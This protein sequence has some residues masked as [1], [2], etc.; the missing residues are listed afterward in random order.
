MK[1]LKKKI[2]IAFALIFMFAIAT[3]LTTIPVADAAVTEF[4]NGVTLAISTDLVGNGQ[5]VYILFGLFEAHPQSVGQEGPRWDGITLEITT[6]DQKT[7]TL[8]PYSAEATGKIVLEYTVDQLG[9]YNFE[10]I[11]PGQWVNISDTNQRW[12]LPDRSGKV[13]LTVQENPI[14]T[15]DKS[16]PLPT[17]YWT[18]PINAENKAWWQVA[19]DWLMLNYNTPQRAFAASTVWAPYTS[20]PNSAHVLWK[21][22]IRFG[23]VSGG[24]SQDS[25][26]HVGIASNQPFRPMI[27]QGRVFYQDQLPSGRALGTRFLDLYTGEEIMYLNDTQI[28]FAQ[29]Y[30][31][32][33]SETEGIYPFIWETSGSTWKMR[34]SMSARLILTFTDM[35][36][37]NIFPGPNGEI[38]KYQFTGSRATRRLTL[39]NSTKAVVTTVNLASG[40]NPF[41]LPLDRVINGTTG[42]EW[43]VSI[44]EFPERPTGTPSVRNMFS[45]ESNVIIGVLRD[46]SSYPPLFY[47]V[48]FPALIEKLSNGSYPDTLNYLWYEKRTNYEGAYERMRGTIQDGKFTQFDEPSTRTFV[49]DVKTGKQLFET[50]RLPIGWTWAGSGRQL[51]YGKLYT[52]SYD[53]NVRAYD[54]E[55]G[56]LL[57]TS[58]L[59]NSGYLENAYGTYPVQEG[60]VIADGKIFVTSGERAVP[61][62]PWRGSKLWVIDAETGQHLWNITGRFRYNSISDGILVSLNIMDGQAYAI[63]KGP[64]STSVTAPDIGIPWGQSIVI[65]GTVTDQSPAQKGTA[66]ISDASMTAWM[67][68]LHMQKPFPTDATG[69]PIKIDVI[70]ANGNYRT[71]GT[72][73]SDTSGNFGFAWTPDIQGSY[74]VKTTFEG[75]NSYGS[76]YSMTYF[77]VQDAPAAT[78][79]PTAPSTPMTDTYLLGATI[80]I[81]LAIAVAVLLI[82]K[83]R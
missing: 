64:T 9:V 25:T 32:S 58:Y 14:A 46:T 48:A 16:P 37:G 44:P 65:K 62:P 50:E 52:A 3:P 28:S 76:S 26:F 47:H 43:S 66:A 29:N 35:T 74:M 51:A 33:E 2:T 17:D 5:S 12:Y 40:T 11:F 68:Y 83:K 10:T 69:V 27:Q 1:L 20:A 60:F 81:I 78:P 71:I 13:S 77:N 23:G 15:Y 34:D 4:F 19:D 72:T 75:S 22:L 80:S 38:L 24:P 73:T 41:N 21:E 53:G 63:G 7:E 39:W 61:S 6:P 79:S 45:L 49:Y 31:F 18:R 67:E 56:T 70:D 42:I 8:G 59:G 36:G 57:W 54:G 55:N 30:F 82:L